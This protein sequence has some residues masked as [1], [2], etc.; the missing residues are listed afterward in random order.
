MSRHRGEGVCRHL[1]R[2]TSW[3]CCNRGPG[4]KAKGKTG[5]ALSHRPWA[6]T[7]QETVGSR[8]NHLQGS[9]QLSQRELLR[10]RKNGK[11]WKHTEDKRGKT[12]SPELRSQKENKH[13]S[14]AL[15]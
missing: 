13:L 14:D 5:K 2:H 4:T 1:Q 9:L 6:W 12:E 15:P 3:F 7:E 11:A 8:G 10:A